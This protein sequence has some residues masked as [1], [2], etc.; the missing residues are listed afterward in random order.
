MTP[1]PPRKF[2]PTSSDPEVTVSA[3]PSV[4]DAANDGL[5]RIEMENL[6]S[7]AGAYLRITKIRSKLHQS[8][9]WIAIAVYS[10]LVSIGFVAF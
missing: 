8:D 9:I 10:V 7:S 6:E 5:S 1:I 3:H 2:R 4:G